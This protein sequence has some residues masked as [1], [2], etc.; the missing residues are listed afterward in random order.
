M[1]KIYAA[2]LAIAILIGLGYD[3]ATRSSHKSK[4]TL[5]MVRMYNGK[6][7]LRLIP[8]SYRLSNGCI[9]DSNNSTILCGVVEVL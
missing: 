4:A 1:I 8:N 2:A 5:R 7:E 3:F 9:L 6:T